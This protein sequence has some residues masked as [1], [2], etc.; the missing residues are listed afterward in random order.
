MHSVP[1]PGKSLQISNN[2]PAFWESSG[3]PK[4]SPRCFHHSICLL[5]SI[6]PKVPKL[7]NIFTAGIL[8]AASHRPLPP[9]MIFNSS[10]L[11]MDRGTQCAAIYSNTAH[12]FFPCC[13]LKT[14]NQRQ[15]TMRRG[16]RTMV[17]C[18][19]GNHT[20]RSLEMVIA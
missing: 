17:C 6:V 4:L 18:W 20:Q 11:K 1:Y 2:Q 7:P 9:L 10:R 3:L 5:Y 12:I 15:E 8:L 19:L 16:K 13:S 14:N